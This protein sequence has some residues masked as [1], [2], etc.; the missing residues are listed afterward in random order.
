MKKLITLFFLVFTLLVNAQVK[1]PAPI[2][3][4]FTAPVEQRVLKSVYNYGNLIFAVAYQDGF[5]TNALSLFKINMDDSSVT[6][7]QL[8]SG[9][10]TDLTSFYNSFKNLGAYNNKLYFQSYN[11]HGFLIKRY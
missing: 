10:F 4:S 5:S 8:P 1:I 2:G 9:N 6:Q 3:Y 11:D 7:I